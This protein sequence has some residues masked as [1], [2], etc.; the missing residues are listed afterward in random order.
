M[1]IFEVKDLIDSA[2]PDYIWGNIPTE[3]INKFKLLYPLYFKNN[4]E[5]WKEIEEYENLPKKVKH[6]L[7]IRIEFYNDNMKN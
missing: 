2:F 5:S 6:H 7:D 4:D 3:I 1:I